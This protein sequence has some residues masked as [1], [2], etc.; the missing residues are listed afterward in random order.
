MQ[1]FD[2]L[3]LLYMGSATESAAFAVFGISKEGLDQALEPFLDRLTTPGR[4]D[5]IAVTFVGAFLS[6]V[7]SWCALRKEWSGSPTNGIP[8]H[9]I[10]GYF[11][12]IRLFVAVF[13]LM[14]QRRPRMS[15]MPAPASVGRI[16][17]LV[18]GQAVD[19]W[20]S[21]WTAREAEVV[22][23]AATEVLR[24]ENLVNV[25]VKIV[26]ETTNMHDPVS[27]NYSFGILQRVLEIAARAAG[28]SHSPDP[29]A[30]TS[31]KASNA[32]SRRRVHRLSDK[33]DDAYFLMVMRRALQSAHVQILLKVLTCL[34]NS[35]GAY[36]VAP[37]HRGFGECLQ[38]DCVW[39]CIHL[40]VFIQIY[41][42]QE[43]GNVSLA[44]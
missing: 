21:Y 5:L 39:R 44:S 7:S 23:E 40:C 20:L 19:P 34:Y 13:Q 12:V 43:F 33:F 18:D 38:C 42:L 29:S 30:S 17:S 41:C 26:L 32:K 35:I 28:S 25:L 24:N 15:V 27:V 37:I 16:L 1:F 31:E 6:D 8:W 11:S 9:C 14:C 2:Q 3:P 10:P 22:L 36:S 4:D